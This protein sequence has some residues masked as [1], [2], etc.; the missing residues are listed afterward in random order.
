MGLVRIALGLLAAIYAGSWL[1]DLNQWLE[2]NGRLNVTVTRFLIGDQVEGTGS[3][4]RLSPLYELESSTWIRG[5]LIATILCSLA[6]AFGM[7]GRTMAALVWILT[8]GIVHRVPI[9]QDAGDL[10]FSGIMGY[11][12]IDPGKTKH[13]KSIGLDDREDRW[14]ANLAKRLMQ[15]HVVGWLAI[16]LV[17]HLAE[18]MWWSASAAW[19]LAAGQRSPW[20]SQDFLSD[21][22]Y[23]INAI[24]HGFIV[25][26]LATLGL[27]LRT[28]CRPLAI[29]ATLLMSIT[30]WGLAGDW[31]YSCALIA[32]TSCFWGIAA[33]ELQTP[34]EGQPNSMDGKTA[35]VKSETQKPV[36]KS[37]RKY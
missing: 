28:G 5:Y 13:W 10:L 22:P 17:S 33:R 8:L 19:W 9:L 6:M 27:F 20:F 37:P 11:L 7:G 4:G 15:C 2:E 18:P 1:F 26:H 31:L 14:T 3:I 32:A 12:I 23:L 35:N 29:G 36:G 21:K 25:I 24:S 34:E 16:S 30:I